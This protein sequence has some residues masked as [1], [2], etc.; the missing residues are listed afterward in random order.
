MVKNYKKNELRAQKL[1][2]VFYSD[3]ARCVNI[4]NFITHV[5]KIE[6][7]GLLIYIPLW[8]EKMDRAIERLRDYDIPRH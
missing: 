5:A 2:D 6:G 4:G 1:R 3:Y 7:S 8:D